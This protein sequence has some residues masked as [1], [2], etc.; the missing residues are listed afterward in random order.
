MESLDTLCVP[1]LLLRC[2]GTSPREEKR[3]SKVPLG[4]RVALRRLSRKSF[5]WSYQAAAGGH[6][7]TMAGILNE[8]NK[9]RVLN[10]TISGS[11]GV[12]CT[13]TG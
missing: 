8:A 7:S 5:W 2:S 3:R 1:Q 10:G 4:M 13:D 9:Q 6:R 12:F 11:V